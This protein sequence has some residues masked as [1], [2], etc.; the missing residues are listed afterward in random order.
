MIELLKNGGSCETC[1]GCSAFLKAREYDLL[2]FAIYSSEITV[3]EL[4]HFPAWPE[5]LA[6]TRYWK[7]EEY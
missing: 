3:T 4:L 5:T 2:R 6:R 1:N 7:A